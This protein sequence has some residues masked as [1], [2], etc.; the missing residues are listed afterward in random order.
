MVA[1]KVAC[2]VRASCSL[3]T[4]LKSGPGKVMRQPSQEAETRTVTGAQAGTAAR[5]RTGSLR[6]TTRR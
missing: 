2:K 6:A 1:C 4:L 5:L 3:P